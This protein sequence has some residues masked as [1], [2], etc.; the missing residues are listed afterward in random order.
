[1]PTPEPTIDLKELSR[2]WRIQ[3]DEPKRQYSLAN[4]VQQYCKVSRNKP[5]RLLRVTAVMT[6]CGEQALAEMVDG[7]LRP[8][9]PHRRDSA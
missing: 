7:Q 6:A 8:A 3:T 9:E 4:I 2:I 5:Y 1:M